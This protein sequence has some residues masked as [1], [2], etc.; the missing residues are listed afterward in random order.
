VAGEKGHENPS[1]GK[2][3]SYS[4]QNP[5]TVVVDSHLHRINPSARRSNHQNT[6][7][8]TEN[9]QE[10]MVLG[11]L[12]CLGSIGKYIISLLP[13]VKIKDNLS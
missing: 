8:K 7:G 2:Q 12:G 9:H 13:L 6:Q 1:L 4:H 5:S 11:H 3:C 10:N